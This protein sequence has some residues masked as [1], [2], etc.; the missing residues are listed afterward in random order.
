MCNEG[1]VPR[2]GSETSTQP[3][4][5]QEKTGPGQASE[6]STQSPTRP[7][8]LQPMLVALA[9]CMVV[10]VIAGYCMLYRTP[11]KH[12]TV[13]E[14]YLLETFKTILQVGTVLFLGSVVNL[15]LQDFTYRR[16]KVDELA[17]RVR[18]KSDE[19]A[20]RVRVDADKEAER[21]RV[22]AEQRMAFQKE[23]LRNLTH[24][25]T[26]I[27]SIRRI[28]AAKGITKDG[29]D[30]MVQKDVYDEQMRALSQAELN[31]ETVW[32]D[33]INATMAFSKSSF[34]FSN[35]VSNSDEAKAAQKTLEKLIKDKLVKTG[36]EPQL[37]HIV[38][39]MKDYLRDIIGIYEKQYK[40]FDDT[41]RLSLKQLGAGSASLTEFLDGGD[42]WD[43]RFV[44]AY[45][46]ASSAI[47]KDILE[48]E[49]QT[50]VVKAFP[51]QRR[52]EPQ[53]EN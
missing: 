3:L 40:K 31:L 42:D 9:C 2:Q 7:P 38:G 23:T 1:T 14:K 43:V 39:F 44:A 45:R 13:Y 47:R 4:L 25:F 30:V 48:P 12:E 33:I 21:A 46:L 6:T 51:D 35:E 36:N 29:S 41:P 11:H 18:V 17:E 22:R 19:D 27:K 34:T 32:Y 49:G 53:K 28:L 10:I 52:I 26:E 15:L 24:S 8:L 20:E 5:P 37:Y 16:Q 50:V